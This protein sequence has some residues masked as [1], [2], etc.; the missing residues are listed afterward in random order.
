METLNISGTEHVPESRLKAIFWPRVMY[1]EDVDYIGTRGYFLCLGIAALN[2]V[3][4]AQIYPNR[5]YLVES[6]FYVTAA[7]GIRQRDRLA[8]IAVFCF[9]SLGIVVNA[10]ASHG[11]RVSPVAIICAGL[12]GTNVRAVWIA[13]RVAMEQ[14]VY[15]IPRDQPRFVEWFTDVFPRHAWPVVRWF[16]YILLAIEA[17]AVIGGTIMILFFP[18]RLTS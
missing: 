8:S 14:A 15:P 13:H 7:I 11:L 9:Y 3:L 2:A 18:H 6:L 4:G 16:F 5:W 10:I 17:L 12:L 1:P